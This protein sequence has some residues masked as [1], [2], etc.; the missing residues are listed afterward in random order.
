[1]TTNAKYAERFW[2]RV[3]KNGSCWLWTGSR[4][5]NGYGHFYGKIDGVVYWRANRFSWALANGSIPDGMFVCHRC[6]NP[7]CVNPDHLFIGD[8]FDNMRDALQK[9]RFANGERARHAKLT[10]PQVIEI[11][12]SDESDSVLAKRFNIDPSAITKIRNGTN[13]KHVS[14]DRGRDHG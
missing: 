8:R 11:K 6:D 1:M 9:G 13:W 12:R 4:T 10:E 3:D 2:S 14:G 7:W 5:Y